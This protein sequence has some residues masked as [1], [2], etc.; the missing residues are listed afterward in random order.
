MP[1]RADDPGRCLDLEM[2]IS[3]GYTLFSQH[4]PNLVA[5]L[6]GRNNEIFLLETMLSAESE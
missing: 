2:Q 4:Y 1:E 5:N 3:P 6:I